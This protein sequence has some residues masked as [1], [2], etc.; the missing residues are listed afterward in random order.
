MTSRWTRTCAVFCALLLLFTAAAAEETAAPVVA[1][2]TYFATPDAADD[3]LDDQQVIEQGALP[4]NIR[5]LLETAAQE[6]G[7]TEESDGYTKYGAWTGDPYSQWC[8]EFICWSIHMT[9][10]LYD[11][12]M[13]NN[14]YPYYTGQNTGRDWFVSRGRFV[15]RRGYQPGWGWQWL[16]DADGMMQPG[17]YIPRPGDLVYFSYNEQGDTVHVA[18]VEFCTRDESGK[19][20]LHVIE[21]NNPSSVQR[22][23]YALDNPQVQGFGC[24][25]DVVD[26]TIQYGNTGD[27]VLALQKDLGRLGYLAER[28]FTATFASNTRNAVATFQQN[29]PGKAPTGIADRETQLAIQYEIEKLE[30]HDPSAWLVTDG[31]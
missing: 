9:D 17:D 19:V 29:M 4:E 13:L 12:S 5:L 3:L 27:K 24:W 11:Y 6:I 20:H 22:S 18:L 7:Y 26:T 23:V 15:Y 8:A 2:E 31:N 28:H 25:A 14:I 21:G 16:K 1:E 10:H 30:L